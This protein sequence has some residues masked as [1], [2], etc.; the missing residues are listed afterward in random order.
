MSRRYLHNIKTSNTL[1]LIFDEGAPVSLP[2]ENPM[3]AKIEDLISQGRFD[4]IDSMLTTPITKSLGKF[5]VDA[6][7]VINIGKKALPRTLSDRLVQFVESGIDTTPLERFWANCESNP[8]PAAVNELFD[9]MERNRVC[10]TADGCFVAYKGVRDDYKDVYSGTY[11]NK[12]GAVISMPR[13]QVDADRRNECSHGFHVGGYSYAHTFGPVL[14]EVKVNPK[15]VVAV[16]QDYNWA[17]MRVCEYEVIRVNPKVERTEQT[18]SG[19]RAPGTKAKK[20]SKENKSGIRRLPPHLRKVTVDATGGIS[21]SFDVLGRIFTKGQ[22]VYAVVANQR[23][24]YLQITATK[25]KGK[26]MAV[27]ELKVGDAT[28][29]YKT[30]LASAQIAGA[31]E[32]TLSFAKGT[33]IVK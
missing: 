2:V 23:T 20:V 10:L 14:V 26:P 17:K 3:Y 18:Y 31:N 21:L 5:Q 6:N 33:V 7:G 1:V 29:L 28:R 22:T 24:R 25:P 9:F 16:P 13:S 30:L 27:K 32:Y 8:I 12:P 15:N 11:D 4:D 19:R